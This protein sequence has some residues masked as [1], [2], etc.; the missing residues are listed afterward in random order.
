MA[1]L[2][3]QP[4]LVTGAAGFIGSHVCDS[5]IADGHQVIGLDS[6]ETMYEPAIKQRNIESLM[7]SPGFTLAQVDIRNRTALDAVFSTHKPGSVI[8]L[9]ALAGV[10]R[11]IEN[12]ALYSDVNVTGTVNTLNAATQ[13]WGAHRGR[14]IFASSS[15]VYGNNQKVPFGECDAVGRPISPYA[16]TKRAGELLCHSYHQTHNLNVSCLR[17]F[18]VYGPRQRPDLAIGKFMRQIARCEQLS[19][20]G[21]GETSR[22]YTYIDDIVSGVRSALDQCDGY[23]LFNLGNSEPIS[24]RNMIATIE[25]T[26]GRKAL[27]KSEPMQTGDVQ[28]TFADL[29]HSRAILGYQPRISFEQGVAMQWEWMRHEYRDVQQ[30]VLD[31]AA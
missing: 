2:S 24:L 29:T 23:N 21:N 12:A 7:G 30:P 18:T 3:Q 1:D 22:D 19:M 14:F 5:L 26:V 27:I 28:R 6:F 31:G 16:A 11:S 10:R 17:F 20:F 13:L 4:I 9:A 8:H 25:N 15:S